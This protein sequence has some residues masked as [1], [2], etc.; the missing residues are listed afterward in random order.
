MKYTLQTYFHWHE[1]EER[2]F[3]REFDSLEAA[4]EFTRNNLCG[5]RFTILPTNE[6]VYE[7]LEHAI[8]HVESRTNADN[9]NDQFDAAHILIEAYQAIGPC[10][11]VP[12]W[13]R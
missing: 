4:E 3:S 9:G 10:G 12:S 5:S 2:G 7:T 8:K 13:E 1:I 11:Q 6:S